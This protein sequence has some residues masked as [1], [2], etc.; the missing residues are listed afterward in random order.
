MNRIAA[1]EGTQV[2]KLRHFEKL[3]QKV[4][5]QKLDVKYFDK[6]I[7]MKLIPDFLKFKPPDL[8]VYKNQDYYAKIVSDQRKLIINELKSSKRKL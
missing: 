5:K 6:C 4:T 1:S 7:E 8:D 3:Y 2:N